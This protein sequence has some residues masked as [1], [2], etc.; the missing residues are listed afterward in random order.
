MNRM[1]GGASFHAGAKRDQDIVE[2][3]DA[4]EPV[5]GMFEV[6]GDIDGGRHAEGEGDDVDPFA[7]RRA[8]HGMAGNEGADE[9]HAEQQGVD[10]WRRVRAQCRR[11][12]RR[13][14]EHLVQGLENDFRRR[15]KGA[16]GAEGRHGLAPDI[17][18]Q[19]RRAGL[20]R[21]RGIRQ[22]SVCRQA[23]IQIGAEAIAQRRL[24]GGRYRVE[25]QI[26]R[27]DRIGFLDDQVAAGVKTGCSMPANKTSANSG[28]RMVSYMRE[29]EAGFENESQT[30]LPSSIRSSRT[31]RQAAL[32]GLGSNTALTV[33]CL[34][35][36]IA[37]VTR[38]RRDSV[39]LPS[40]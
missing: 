15:G 7:P 29:T 10:D 2:G 33:R 12:R 1:A 3:I 20:F 38:L 26:S 13:N 39:V 28:A 27:A 9:R 35:V 37:H 32:K 14:I 31:P 6:E 36:D 4:D 34:L 40:I 5:A 11:P 16:R 21:G 25:P 19:A 22:L 8:G 30:S 17:A 24:G 18:L 23:R